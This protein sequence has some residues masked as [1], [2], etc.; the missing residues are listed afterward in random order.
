MDH[1]I[2]QGKPA[3]DRAAELLEES[4]QVETALDQLYESLLGLRRRLPPQEW[5]AFCRAYCVS[6]PVRRL[7]HQ[8]PLTEHAFFK[9]RGYAGDPGLLDFYYG[10]SPVAAQLEAATDLGRRIY[11]Y[12]SNTRVGRALRRRR[13]ILATLIDKVS[14]STDACRVLTLDCGY[15][16]EAELCTALRERRIDRFV[17]LDRDPENLRVVQEKYGP[18]GVET[19]ITTVDHL[20]KEASYLGTFDLIYASGLYDYLHRGIAARLTSALFKITRP[21][22]TLLVTNMVPGLRDVGYMEA[23]MDW[24]I[25]FRDAQEMFSLASSIPEQE[26]ADRRTFAEESGG[27]VF[28]LVRRR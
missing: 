14:F 2:H 27:I 21:G 22:G 4:P 28:M 16:R 6:H 12:T 3:L 5:D 11:A 24:R 9:P 15:L 1:V 23:F 13:E 17:A 10:G 26:I 19:G 18:L 25:E 8:D 20:L 7:V